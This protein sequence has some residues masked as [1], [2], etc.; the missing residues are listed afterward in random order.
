MDW[1]DEPATRRQIKSLKELGYTLDHRLTKIEAAD[2]I[3]NLGGK[4]EGEGSLVGNA[5]R[6]AA[7][8]DAYQLRVKADKARR[9]SV[10]AGREKPE[11][12]EHELAAAVTERQDFWIET[13]QGSAKGSVA[14][15]QIHELYQK[16]GCR[17][18]APARNEVQYILD[19]LDAAM[20]FWD[21]DNP[22]LFYQTLELN[23]PAHLRR[24]PGFAC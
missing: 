3:R 15:M 8:P 9:A 5:S 21:R 12:V 24:S 22:E 14:L 2:L 23:F 19:A 18:E 7:A 20:P 16:Y 11:K 4:P 13:C 6:Q 10:D 17:F 1:T